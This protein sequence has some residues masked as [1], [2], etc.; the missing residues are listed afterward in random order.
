MFGDTIRRKTVFGEVF[1]HLPVVLPYTKVCRRSIR[2]ATFYSHLQTSSKAYKRSRF[3]QFQW[4]FPSL[5]RDGFGGQII[6]KIHPAETG[7][8]H[9]I[10]GI[11]IPCK[12]VYRRVYF[13]PLL[14]KDFKSWGG[15]L[16]KPLHKTSAYKPL[17]PIT[18]LSLNVYGLLNNG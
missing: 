15:F 16:F 5:W 3:F 9:P 6:H 18:G 8:T 13:P 7:Q 17:E 1:A 12:T 14:P 4:G 10:A 2:K 11:K